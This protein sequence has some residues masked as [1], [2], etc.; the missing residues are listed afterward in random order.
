MQCVVCG[1]DVA[2]ARLRCGQPW[3]ERSGVN[4]CDTI[5]TRAK[6]AGRTREEQHWVDDAFFVDNPGVGALT[7][8]HEHDQP[9]E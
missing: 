3:R 1:A 6:H 4:T 5:C 2:K 8:R 7:T 9:E